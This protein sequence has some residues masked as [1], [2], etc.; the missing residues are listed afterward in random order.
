MISFN[1]GY[2]TEADLKDAGFRSMGRNVRIAVNTTIVGVENIEIGDNV[3]IDGFST[4]SVPS[5]GWLKI[6]NY[7]HI[8]GSCLLSAGDGMSLSDFI[9]I[10]YGSRIYSR[11]DDFGGEYLTGPMVPEKFTRYRRGPVLLGKHVVVGT[12]TVVLP[13]IT[14]GEGSSVG[15]LSLVREDLPPW[16][17]YA[18]IP[19]QR[20]RQRSKNL[21]ELEAL[22]K[23]EEKAPPTK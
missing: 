6:G 5:P 16:G 14:I 13:N 21:L 23:T 11:T 15:A 20:L 3:R 2:Y 4:L 12:S 7:I 18:G 9:S 8:A 17:V 19:A 22:L 10:S 1:P